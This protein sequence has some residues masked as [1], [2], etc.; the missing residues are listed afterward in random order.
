M[1]LYLTIAVISVLIASR[2]QIDYVEPGQKKLPQVYVKDRLDRQAVM[3]SIGLTA[4]VLFLSSFCVLRVHTG[5][6]YQ[7]YIN[8]FHDIVCGN[9]VVTEKGFNW[10]VKLVYW[11][12]DEENYLVIFGIFGFAT[13]LIFVKA[14]YEQSCDFQMSFFLYMALGLYFQT[15]NTVRYY[16]ALGIVFYSIRYVIRNEYVKFIVAI[17]IASLFHKTALI[18]IPL[19]I[20]AKIPWKKWMLVVFALLSLT[21]L[22]MEDFYMKVFLK[23]YP[24]YLNEEEYLAGGGFSYVNIA[25]CLAVL[26]FSLFVY[27]RNGGFED[28][29]M[30]FY[31]YLNLGA[32]ALYTCFSFIP[33]VSRIGYYLNIT[34]LLYLPMLIRYL[35]QGKVRTAWKAIILTAG[36]LYFMIFLDKATAMNVRILPYSTWLYEDISMMPLFHR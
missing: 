7:T 30:K 26:V 16:F 22:F 12:L 31:F 6:D 2:I 10:I 17:L 4:L 14:L 28:N 25:R 8:H 27:Y 35:P 1:I 20:L 36:L 34:H 18:V 33:F 23:L 24:S 11:F 5:N 3:N 29:N 32:L 19:Y 13:V 21:G 9:Y 15:Y